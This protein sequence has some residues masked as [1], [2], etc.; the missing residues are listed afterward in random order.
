VSRRDDC[1]CVN[2]EVIYVPVPPW[3]I[4]ATPETVMANLGAEH[5]GHWVSAG[6]GGA[7]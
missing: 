4:P 1:N 5:Y 2:D 3:R 6:K 7:Q